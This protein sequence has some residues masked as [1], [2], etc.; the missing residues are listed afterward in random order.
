MQDMKGYR[1]EFLNVLKE[2]NNHYD[3][4][5][6]EL[7]RNGI[8]FKY[9][10]WLHPMQGEWE[11]ISLFTDEILNNISK[12]IKPNSTVIDIGAQ[13]GNMSVAYSLFA[14][15]VISFECNPATYE[16]LE[17]NAE[18]H[19]NIIPFNYA[20]S[21]D[22]GPLRFHYSD[23]GLC[24]GGYAERT[25]FGVGVTGHQI[26]IDVWGVNLDSFLEKNSLI[27]NEVS[28][29]KID[30]EGHD[31]DILK[32]L[33]DIIYRDSPVIITEIY[34]GLNSIEMREMMNVIN[35]IGYTAYDEVANKL[36]IENLGDEV[37]L[38]ENDELLSG[39]N[40]ICVPD[41]LEVNYDTK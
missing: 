7:E 37:V 23:D 27:D 11:L 31:K 40:L 25:D 16:V 30:T 2:T 22:E 38:M 36:D 32:T 14:D 6:V 9:H 29:I 15:K 8:T 5:I 21:D 35:N 1:D 19:P 33:V 4:E 17:K 3:T 26:P 12:I 20:V 39:H 41:K 28:L 34:T 13:S 18:L 24:N 10:R